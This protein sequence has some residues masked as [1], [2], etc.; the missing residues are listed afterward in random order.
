MICGVAT[1]AGRR[2]S[3]ACWN[4]NTVESHDNNNRHS[5][6]SHVNDMGPADPIFTMKY[7]SKWYVSVSSIY[8][9]IARLHCTVILLWRINEGVVRRGVAQ[10][11]IKAIESET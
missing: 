3:L 1:P 10:S 4:T 7:C 9:V 8:I 6:R 5:N 11:I 2:G